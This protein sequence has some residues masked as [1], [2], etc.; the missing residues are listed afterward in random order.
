MKE[1]HG[2]RICQPALLT[3]LVDASQAIEAN[4]TGRRMGERKVCSPLKTAVMYQPSGFTSV[5]TMAQ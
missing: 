2:D 1:Q 5:T 4:S 3:L